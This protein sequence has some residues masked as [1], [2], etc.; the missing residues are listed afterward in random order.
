MKVTHGETPLMITDDRGDQRWIGIGKLSYGG[1]LGSISGSVYG[2]GGVRCS[3]SLQ[4]AMSIRLHIRDDLGNK[5]TV[6][7]VLLGAPA[8]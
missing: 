6:E 1:E 4:Q 2:T 8:P 3:T 5:R 7:A